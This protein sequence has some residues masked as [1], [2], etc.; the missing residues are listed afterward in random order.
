MGWST[1]GIDPVAA[2]T[3]GSW[4]GRGRPYRGRGRLY[5]GLC[6]GR[7]G[8]PGRNRAALPGLSLPS[9]WHPRSTEVSSMFGLRLQRYVQAGIFL[10]F[11]SEVKMHRVQKHSALCLILPQAR[12]MP[13]SQLYALWHHFTG[14]RSIEGALGVAYVATS[15]Q[16]QLLRPMKPVSQRR[17]S[18]RA[19]PLHLDRPSLRE[20]KQDLASYS[21]RRRSYDRSV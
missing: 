10:C 4:H 2:F 19:T 11:I 12:R 18:Q 7:G 8:R 16:R 3:S 13:T 6:R 1:P 17:A 5:R 15:C 9:Q 20:G 14:C 21:N